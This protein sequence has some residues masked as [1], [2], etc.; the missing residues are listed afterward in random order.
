[1]NLVLRKFDG[2]GFSTEVASNQFWLVRRSPIGDMLVNGHKLCRNFS[3]HHGYDYAGLTE[4]I[5]TE[6]F[7]LLSTGAIYV[8]IYECI[9][10]TIRV[11]TV[12]LN[13]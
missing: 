7:D 8:V 1:M 2:S 4:Q 3:L 10:G 6:I 12:Q 9:L 13:K 11:F 5:K